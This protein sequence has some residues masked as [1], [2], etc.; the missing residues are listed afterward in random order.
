[1][2]FRVIFFFVDIAKRFAQKLIRSPQAAAPFQ[3]F[4]HGHMIVDVLT[5]VD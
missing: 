5:V 3:M 1:M 4:I 2:S